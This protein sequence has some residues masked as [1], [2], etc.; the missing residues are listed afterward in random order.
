MRNFSNLFSLKKQIPLYIYYIGKMKLIIT[1][2]DNIKQL[3]SLINY[4]KLLSIEVI[5][6][7]YVSELYSI[8]D[9]YFEISSTYLCIYKKSLD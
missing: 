3:L 6:V 4:A 1:K 8:D 7:E 5:I 9:I 2:Y